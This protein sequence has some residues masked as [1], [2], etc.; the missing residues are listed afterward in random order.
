MRR[1]DLHG[2]KFTRLTVLRK[3]GAKQGRTAWLCQCECGR[4][5]IVLTHRLTTGH[6]RSCGCLDHDRMLTQT[7]EHGA[8]K[9]GKHLPEYDRWIDMRTR[10]NNPRTRDWKNYGGRGIKICK[11]WDNFANFLADMGPRPSR[12]HSLDRIDNDG[13]YEPKNCRWATRKE[14]LENR[15]R[16]DHRAAVI[17]SW[18]TR[19]HS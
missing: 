15:R 6:T 8:A 5:T 9:R 19:K 16:F 1:K 17:K 2:S 18:K 3:A 13:N 4:K 7:L 14:Q 10:C 12:F 11:R